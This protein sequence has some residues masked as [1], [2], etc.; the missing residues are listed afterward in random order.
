MPCTSDP[1]ARLSRVDAER[2]RHIRARLDA[3]WWQ[4]KLWALKRAEN[5]APAASPSRPLASSQG[6]PRRRGT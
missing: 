4:A 2:I 3:P 5:M 6:D 1:P